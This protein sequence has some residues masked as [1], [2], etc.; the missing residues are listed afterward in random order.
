[1]LEPEV[2]EVGVQVEVVKGETL[3][4]A[5]RER[6]DV[7]LVDDLGHGQMGGRRVCASKLSDKL[8]VQ[9]C[10]SLGSATRPRWSIEANC[11]V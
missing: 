4:A 9:V 1:M 10:R 6:V 7:G 3:Q 2:C 5:D 11:S 8:V